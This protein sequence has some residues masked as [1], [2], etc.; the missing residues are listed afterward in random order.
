[1]SNPPRR[2]AGVTAAATFAILGCGTA[3]LCWGYLLISILN[4]ATDD[5]GKHFYEAYPAIFLAFA[6]VPSSVIAVGIRTGIGLFQLRPWARVSAMVWAV[7]TMAF[8][9]SMIAL[10]PFETFF[11]ADHF[12]GELESFKQLISMALIILL[13][14][15][16]VWW[17]FLFR[18]KSVKE[19]FDAPVSET[20]GNCDALT[21]Q[22]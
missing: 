17:L 2:S 21:T 8:C 14:P 3:F 22:E 16:S 18:V 11:I 5:K 19:Q 20:A 6:L 4:A 10:R 7:I 13:L 9:L 12:V 1:M 15:C